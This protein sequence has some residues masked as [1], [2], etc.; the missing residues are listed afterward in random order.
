[1]GDETIPEE[2]IEAGTVGIV[3]F[4]RC[5]PNP[6]PRTLNQCIFTYIYICIYVYSHIY[7][8]VCIY[9]YMI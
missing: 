6:K 2:L 8:Y 1:M 3:R 9:I 4:L 5:T 7:I